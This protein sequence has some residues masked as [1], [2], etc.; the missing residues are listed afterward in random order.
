MTRGVYGISFWGAQEGAFNG[1]EAFK[2]DNF[3][4]VTTSKKLSKEYQES[5]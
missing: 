5:L 4:F 3:I 2:R 1:Q